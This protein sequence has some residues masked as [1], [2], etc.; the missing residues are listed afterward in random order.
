MVMMA[1]KIMT[2]ISNG[3]VIAFLFAAATFAADIKSDYDRTVD[4]SRLA[5]FTFSDQSRRSPKDALAGNELVAKRLRNAIQ[6]NLLAIGMEHR[7]VQPDFEVS[8]YA[9]QKNQVQVTTSGRPRW[10]AGAVWV[11]QYVEGTAIVEFRDGRS[12]QL[13]WRGYVTSAV[14]P[15]KSEQRINDSIKKLI[16]RFSKDR[17]KQHAGKR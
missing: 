13:V 8:Y 2:R 7:E 9:A 3:L 12:R 17:E 14:D 11:D 6:T 10:G 5:S 4:L 15:N 1:M 16:A